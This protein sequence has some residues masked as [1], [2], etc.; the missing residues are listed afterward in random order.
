MKHEWTFYAEVVSVVDGD[1]LKLNV[2]KGFRDFRINENFRLARINAPELRKADPAG[3]D[4]KNALYRFLVKEWEYSNEANNPK[5]WKPLIIKSS[6]HGKYR[7]V[8]EV[9]VQDKDG[10]FSIN[11]NDWMVENGHAVYQEY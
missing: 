5:T 3:H 2:D 4:S 10:E 7:W 9:F 6:K 11:V 1:T 8:I